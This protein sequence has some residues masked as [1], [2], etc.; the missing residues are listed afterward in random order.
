VSEEQLETLHEISRWL[1]V[2][3]P[4]GS[5]FDRGAEVDL[6][7]GGSRIEIIEFEVSPGEVGVLRD[8][9]TQTETLSDLEHV[10]FSLLRDGAGVSG[11]VEWCGMKGNGAERPDPLVVPLMGGQKI[12]VVATNTSGIA[13][14]NVAARLKGW[15]WNPSME[16]RS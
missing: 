8:V 3:P 15:T 9:G 2:M 5:A 7:A 14:S 11:Y 10:T 6:A 1:D 12:S 13:L 4:W 16:P